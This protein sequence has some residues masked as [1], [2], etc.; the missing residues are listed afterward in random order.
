MLLS[1]Y[2]KRS[3]E[4]TAKA[5]EITRQLCL[6]GVAII[7]LFKSTDDKQVLAQATK[8]ILEPYLVWPLFFLSLAMV[9]D[10]AQYVVGG[11]IWISF[12]RKK[13][14][15]FPN[16]DPDIKADDSL[17]KPIYALYYIKISLMILAYFFIVTYLAGKLA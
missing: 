8:P 13:E 14:K 11:I 10:L 7:W 5:S 6:A 12:F 1:E 9:C 2:R 3:H 15:E 16:S 4:Y 17:N